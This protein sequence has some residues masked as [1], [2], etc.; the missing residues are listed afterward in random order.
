MTDTQMADGHTDD[1]CRMPDRRQG[2]EDRQQT[3]QTAGY[4]RGAGNRCQTEGGAERRQTDG[5]LQTG[6]RQWVVPRCTDTQLDDRSRNAQSG[7][8][9]PA[10]AHRWVPTLCPRGP[11]NAAST[12]SPE[13]LVPQRHSQQREPGS[14]EKQLFQ[15]WGRENTR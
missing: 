5:R 11:R 9:T 15:A 10:L 2:P 12:P 3:E 13:G 4:R 6:H 14:L 1:R 7:P 8:A